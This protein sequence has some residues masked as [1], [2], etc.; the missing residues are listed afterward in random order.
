MFRFKQFSVADERS[1]Q[2]VCTDSVLLGAWAKL[3]TKGRILDVGTGCGV[4]ALQCAQRSDCRIIGIDIHEPSVQ[5][6]AENFNN[7]PWS[8]RL[9]ALC[10]ALQEYYSGEAF[11]A[12]ISNPPYFSNSLKSPFALR[13]TTRHDE[14]LTLADFFQ[15]SSR[16]LKPGGSLSVCLPAALYERALT[17][18]SI[19]GFYPHSVLNVRGREDIHPYL[20]LLS[21]ETTPCLLIMDNLSIRNREG[22]YTEAYQ[23][24]TREFYLNF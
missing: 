16:L 18:A 6:A 4:I 22:K 17:L 21:F 24:L 19:N 7:S 15:H 11:D 1:T 13:N 8:D 14:E 20:V 12:V 3:P 2:K 9:E 10:I 5:Q 23:N